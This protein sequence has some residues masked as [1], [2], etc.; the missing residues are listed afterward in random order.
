MKRNILL[1]FFLLL[2]TPGGYA[3]VVNA[4]AKVTGISL[5]TL[6]LTNVKETAEPSFKSG[7]KIIIMQMQDNVIGDVSQTASFGSLGDIRSTGLY[8]V[9]EIESI[10]LSGGIPITV[11]VSS[12]Q[13][14]FN[15]CDNCSVQII[16]YPTLGTPDYSTVSDIQAYNWNGNIGGV[17]AF[18]VNGTLTLNHSISANGAGFR[19]GTGDADNT[20]GNCNGTSYYSSGSNSFAEKGEGIYKNLNPGFADAKGRIVTGGGGGNS[21]NGGGGGGGNFSAGG[22]GGPGYQ[23]TESSSGGGLGGISLES[24]ISGNRIFMGGG[25]GGGEGNNT[26]A[27]KGGN[28]GGIILIRAN[29]IKTNTSCTGLAISAN[30]QSTNTSTDDGAGGGGA[31]GAIVL[32]VNE[33]TISSDCPLSISTNGGNGGNI[34]HPDS[35][36]GGGGGG[37]G[38]VIFSDNQP[39]IN[40]NTSTRNG[41]GGCNNNSSPC[42][43]SATSGSGTGNKGIFNYEPTPLPVQLLHFRALARFSLVELQWSTLSEKDNAFF[44]LERSANGKNWHTIQTKNGAANSN[45]RRDYYLEDKRPLYGISYYRLKQ[46]DFDGKSTLLGTTVV[47]FQGF[48]PYRFHPNPSDGNLYFEFPFTNESI[49]I[50]ILDLAGKSVL[51]EEI[52]PKKDR[53]VNATTLKNGLYVMKI[54]TPNQTFLEKVVIRK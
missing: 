37:Q 42:S 52:E 27:T 6:S 14:T 4:Y 35:H 23:C 47:Q 9:L 1:F 45:S 2:F 48:A 20:S 26:H 51:S 39:L 12:I 13:N 18:R 54:I 3:Q 49:F 31:G 53:F 44:T 22:E 15:I 19:G 5:N 7:E 33:F 34:Q 25:G 30:G 24:T 17:V 29:E 46:S 28:G 10:T 16:S 41:T 40:V 8:E 21:H 36:G 38:V 32:T 43:F 11:T 50:E